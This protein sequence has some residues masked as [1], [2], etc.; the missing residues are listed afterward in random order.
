MTK[1]IDRVTEALGSPGMIT[2][3]FLMVMTWATV[4]LLLGLITTD[5][6]QLLINTSTTIITFLMVFVIQNAANRSDRAMQAKLDELIRALNDARND[7]RG[8]E[9]LPEKKIKQVTAELID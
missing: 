2:V 7:F 9:R 4:G 1:V 3:A 6:Y 5:P 8:I